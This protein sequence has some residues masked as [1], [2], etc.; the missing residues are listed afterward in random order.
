MNWLGVLI[1][2]LAVIAS[3]DN[4]KPTGEA[5]RA[6]TANVGDIVP[7]RVVPPC[8][9]GI[10]PLAGLSVTMAIVKEP[11]GGG[12]GSVIGGSGDTRCSSRGNGPIVVNNLL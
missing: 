3:A 1:S 7:P 5:Q 4:A 12:S 11:S 8:R 10:C 9:R 2:T 6:L